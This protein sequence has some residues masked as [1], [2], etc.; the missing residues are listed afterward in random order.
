MTEL[1]AFG[2]G[3]LVLAFASWA[4]TGVLRRY[5]LNRDVLDHPNARSSHSVPTPRG[6][7]L[8]IVI[9][10]MAVLCLLPGLGVMQGSEAMALLF[11]GALC[12]GIGFVDDHGHVS[13]RW[14][15][16]AHFG[17]AA[18]MVGLLSVSF[19][20]LEVWGELPKVLVTSFMLFGS[21]WLLNLYNF[22]D[23]IDGLA[24]AEAVSV[25]LLGSMMLWATGHTESTLLPLALAAASAG[26]LVWNFPRARIFMGDAGS[27]FIGLMLAGIMLWLSQFGGKI[28]AAWLVLI[29]TFVTDASV[30]LMRR[31][32]RGQRVWEA[33]R[34]HAYQRLS[35]HIGSH[36]RV[37]FL[38]I[39]VNVF[40][41]G[42]LSVLTGLGYVPIWAGLCMAYAPLAASAWRLGAGLPD[43]VPVRGIVKVL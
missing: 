22:M 9:C 17:G 37:T 19:G 1:L 21:V 35:R 43:D 26:F 24:G 38:Y 14:R 11:G 8:A 18:C 2:L 5:A 3:L 7:G 20:L 28:A 13:A 29:A 27:G 25:C 4:L 40:W 33:H 30:T 12:A 36:V 39:A 16:L 42:P 6:G 34:S 41:L 15:L 10:F 23:G 31:L 32:L